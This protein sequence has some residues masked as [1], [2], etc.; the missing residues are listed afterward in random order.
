MKNDALPPNTT[1]AAPQNET[2][3]RPQVLR[4][5]CVDFRFRDEVE[6]YMVF[7]GLTK[8]Y[9]E[10]TLPGAS[11]GVMNQGYPS[12]EKAFLEQFLLLKKIHHFDHVIF[13]D[14]T[15]CGMFTL[16]L[17]KNYPASP[18]ALDDCHKKQMQAVMKHLLTHMPDLTFEGVIMD[19]DGKVRPLV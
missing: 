6:A 4:V 16:M 14:H 7:R 13:M 8:N 2:V 5:T 3:H 12:W 17:G 10:I 18:E 1:S 11:L 9:D 15:D 19:L